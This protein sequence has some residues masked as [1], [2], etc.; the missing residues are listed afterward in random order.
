MIHK[1]QFIDEQTGEITRQRE[2]RFSTMTG[3]GYKFP[4]NKQGITMFGEM[5]FPEEM[6]FED[7][8]RITRLCRKFIVGDTNLLG[9]RKG[10]YIVPMTKEDI[11]RIGGY[12][13]AKRGD[14]F[15]NR[16]IGYEII[17]EVSVDGEPWYCV[18]PAYYMQRGKRL[19][20]RL[21]IEFQ[22]QLKDLLPKWAVDNFLW[23]ARKQK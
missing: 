21:Y 19:P 2:T 12:E 15:I 1:T 6:S 20:L 14:M 4:H 22:K 10:R 9:H 5:D 18:N 13:S 16:M 11:A 7:I 8:G 3:E 17:K 23:Q